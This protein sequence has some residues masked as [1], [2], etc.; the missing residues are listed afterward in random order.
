MIKKRT[1]L[2]LLGAA[3]M[4]ACGGGNRYTISGTIEDDAMAARMEGKKVYLQYSWLHYDREDTIDS[5]VIEN[6]RFSFRGVV[7]TPFIAY[8]DCSDSVCPFPAMDAFVVE[9]GDIELRTKGREDV[10]RGGTP[11]N[12]KLHEAR[13]W[14]EK[15]YDS[16]L[17]NPDDSLLQAY[18]RGRELA[19]REAVDG[20]GPMFGFLLGIVGKDAIEHEYELQNQYS[21]AV[22]EYATKLYH[23][24]KG[25]PLG[26]Y[27]IRGI[28]WGNAHRVWY[29][30]VYADS[31]LR[32]LDP[33][34][35]ER[36]LFE[37]WRGAFLP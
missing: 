21:D 14:A 16:L 12:K 7:D 4:A 2:A 37:E 15:T 30:T 28:C 9:P 35:A 13:M 20:G 5:T 26:L 10:F 33:A 1:I 31:L 19:K 32:V 22:V 18:I 25:N 27:A 6:G 24:N 11:L 3:L 23:E 34:P 8:L 17:K 36:A 29:D